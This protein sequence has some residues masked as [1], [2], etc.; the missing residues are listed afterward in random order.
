[1]GFPQP[2]DQLVVEIGFSFDEHVVAAF[3][4]AGRIST[5]LPRR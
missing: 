1:V 3:L 4:T 5:A 2:D